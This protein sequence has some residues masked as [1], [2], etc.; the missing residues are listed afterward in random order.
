MKINELHETLARIKEH[1]GFIRYLKNTSWMMTEHSLR[2]VAG[3]FVGIWVARYLGPEQFGLFSYVLAFTAIFG[4]IAKLGLDG[5]MVR[6]LVNHPEKRDYYL[7]TAFWLKIL[8]ALLVM[9]LLASIVP[10]TSNDS[11]TNSFIF[12]I[13]AGLLFQSFEVVEFYFQSQVLAKIISICKVVQLALSSIIKIYLVLSEAELTHFVLVTAFDALSLA[14]SYA[15]AYKLQKNQAFYI[16]I[17][18]NIAKQLLKDSWPLICSSIFV[19]IYMRIDQ[20]MIKEML[21]EYEVGIYS[22]AVRL[23]EVWYFIPGIISASLFPAILN[24]KNN[25][26]EYERRIL[27]LLKLVFLISFLIFIVI[28]FLSKPIVVFLFGFEYIESAEI[29]S[30]HIVGLVFAFSGIASSKWFLSENLQIYTFKRTVIGAIVNV[31]LNYLMIPVWGVIGASYATVIS[32]ILASYLINATSERTR[33]L[34]FIQTK[35]F[36]L[37]GMQ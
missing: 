13:S 34:F 10:F 12:I 35:A 15:I 16:K 4:G 22:A 33:N 2:L 26:R 27:N 20:I 6:E 14:A 9:V 36:F 28:L 5:I 23:S 31:I 30:V 19:M 29:L 24:V 11:V 8:G 32:Q 37:R 18:L 7:G 1:T 17:D 21:G 25:Q 3:L